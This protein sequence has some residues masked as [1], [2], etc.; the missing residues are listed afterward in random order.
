MNGC[1]FNGIHEIAPLSSRQTRSFRTFISSIIIF[2][3]LVETSCL[4]GQRHHISQGASVTLLDL[5]WL[6]LRLVDEVDTVKVRLVA[7]G[8][9]WRLRRM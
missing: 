7:F 6:K 8:T 4:P 9:G 2:I 5:V 1:F 3:G